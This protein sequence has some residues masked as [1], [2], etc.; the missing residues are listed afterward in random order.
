MAEDQRGAV[1]EEH[2]FNQ[3]ALE[4]YL[5]NRLPGF[6]AD[7]S[8]ALTVE[9]YR[10]GQ[11]NPTFHLQKGPKQYVLRKKPPGFLLPGRHQID[12]EYTVQRA[13]TSVG[14]PVPRPLL[15]CED[16]NVIGTEFYIMEH[17]QGRIFR[18]NTISGVSPAEL[19][20][21][22][23][24]VTETLAWLHSLNL[25]ELD[26][27][28]NDSWEGYCKR[29]ILAW[30]ELYEESCHVAI[31]SMNEL[32]EW[33]LSNLPTTDDEPKL[34]HGDFRIPNVIFHPTEA[35]VVAVLDWEFSSVG[36]AVADL[37]Y[38]S[39]P[40]AVKPR[41]N[42]DG[43]KLE[44]LISV[45][46]CCRNVPLLLNDW[47][48]FLALAFFRMAAN[49]QVLYS[50]SLLGNSNKNAHCLG[51]MV[52]PLAEHGLKLRKKTTAV[53]KTEASAP[54]ATDKLFLKSKKGENI[55]LQVKDFMKQYVYPSEQMVSKEEVEYHGVLCAAE[56]LEPL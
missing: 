54:N 40:S 56:N 33:L 14:F 38:F 50:G 21:F 23:D 45:Y 46:Y 36:P 35:R 4:R 2:R 7:P 18:H 30:K 55:L 53:T 22:N 49:C 25:N 39:V 19:C 43:Y 20:A 13:L 15:Y 24:A 8:Q 3:R 34:L 10:C 51:E 27:P 6:P 52:R 29:E 41:T 31:P 37:A 5:E 17:V 16:T 1:R 42:A 32:S 44:D 11:S 12:Q 48:F 47:N 28:G 26:L 9:Q